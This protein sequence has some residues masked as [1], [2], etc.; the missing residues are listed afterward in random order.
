MPEPVTT[1]PAPKPLLTR[2][3]LREYINSQ[4]IPL[5]ASTLDKLCMP[6]RNEGP[7]VEAWWG[8][9]PLYSP[10]RGLEWAR[11]RL[12]KTRKRRTSA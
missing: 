9:R 12:S 2:E 5:G 1:S 11:S 8:D 7:E 4:G 10:E 6:S 3:E